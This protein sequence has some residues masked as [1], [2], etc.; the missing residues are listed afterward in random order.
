MAVD[1]PEDALIYNEN[2]SRHAVRELC[3]YRRALCEMMDQTDVFSIAGP[4]ATKLGHDKVV[5]IA[6]LYSPDAWGVSAWRFCL[7]LFQHDMV[8]L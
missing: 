2:N 8:S 3:R 7:D 1:L 4:D 5:E 6:V